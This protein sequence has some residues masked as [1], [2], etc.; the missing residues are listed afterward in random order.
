M[1]LRMKRPCRY[2]S[3]PELVEAGYCKA[4]E[5][6]QKETARRKDRERGTRTERGYD[7]TW[8]R[9]RDYILRR[10]PLCRECRKQGMIVIAEHVHHIDGDVR[11]RSMENLAPLCQSCHSRITNREQGGWGK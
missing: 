9:L 6:Y 3:C 11:N 10:E 5:K 7:N 8:L 2:P 4:H 1:A